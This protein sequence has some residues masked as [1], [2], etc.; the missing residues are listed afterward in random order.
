MAAM[1]ELYKT[2]DPDIF[3]GVTKGPHVTMS[4]LKLRL[5]DIGIPTNP[6]HA[7]VPVAGDTGKAIVPSNDNPDQLWWLF[8]PKQD[9]PN[10]I[11]EYVLYVKGDH[12]WKQLHGET[13]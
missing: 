9:A 2:A 13:K 4:K 5:V 1:I 6:I 11:T 3:D 12:G 8:D 10:L 7:L